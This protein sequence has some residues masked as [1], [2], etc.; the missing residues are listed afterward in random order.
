MNEF[1]YIIGLSLLCTLG[2][3][4]PPIMA[5]IC[6]KYLWSGKRYYDEH[7]EAEF[8]ER[9]ESKFDEWED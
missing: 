8:D 1:L 6:K 9:E 5:Y 2:A 3:C 7:E 4:Y